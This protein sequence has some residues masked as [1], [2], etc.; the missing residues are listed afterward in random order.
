MSVKAT[1]KTIGGV[2]AKLGFNYAKGERD[3]EAKPSQPQP[4]H[5]LHSRS[6]LRAAS[7]PC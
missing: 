3:R 5:Q 6:V 7:E 4:G 2:G 1:K